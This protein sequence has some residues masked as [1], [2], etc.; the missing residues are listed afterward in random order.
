M[1]NTAVAPRA[2]TAPPSTGQA[3]GAPL[4]VPKRF[5]RAAMEVVDTAAIDVSNAVGAAA[6]PLGPFDLP[7]RGYLRSLLIY[8][9]ATGGTGTAAVY[10]EDAPWIA[11]QDI[12]LQDIN[13]GF[14][15]G[16]MSGYDL[17]LAHKYGGYAGFGDPTISPA[18]VTPTTAGNFSFLVR[19]PVEVNNRDALAAI[20]NRNSAAT[21]K[22]RLTQSPNTVI[23]STNPTGAPTMRVR[24]WEELWSQPAPMDGHG[25]PQ[26]EQPPAHGTT[27]FWS[28]ATYVVPAGNFA[29]RVQRM[30]NLIREL[31]LIYRTTAPARSDSS[32]PNPIRLELESHAIINE[33]RNIRKHYMKERTGFATLDTGVFVYD[34]A[35]DLDGVIG[36][37]MRDQWIE[38]SQ[39]TRLEFVGSWGAA[40]TVDVLTNDIVPAPGADIFLM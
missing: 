9:E 24:V 18:Y 7:A 10:R 26:A 31:V 17:Y 34:M 11:L 25:R 40:G 12:A 3:G 19:L 29:L 8:V 5:T 23:Y 38:T 1:P 14:I 39:A 15:F 37:E 20:G 16:P 28:K 27:Q 22:L 35:H 13:G 2:T 33:D 36:G 4:I 32:F 21:Y 30:G 6:L